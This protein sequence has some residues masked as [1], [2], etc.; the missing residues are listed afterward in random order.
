MVEIKANF[1]E[2]KDAAQKIGEASGAKAVVLFGSRARGDWGKYS[3][4][5]LF[6]VAETNLPYFKRT[7][8]LNKIL[9]EY[10]FPVDLLLYTPKEYEDVKMNK[11][12]IAH[13]VSHDGKV[14]YGNL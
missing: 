10:S 6:V 3:D 8:K 1:D 13:T 2:I 11:A 9:R 4:V 5:D 14:L 7:R 12:S